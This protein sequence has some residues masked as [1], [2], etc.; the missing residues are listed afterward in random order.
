ME[1]GDKFDDNP[2]DFGDE[3]IHFAESYQGIVRK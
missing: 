3:S 2:I 1:F